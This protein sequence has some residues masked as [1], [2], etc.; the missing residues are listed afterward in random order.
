M[1]SQSEKFRK[2]SACLCLFAMSFSHLTFLYA[3]VMRDVLIQDSFMPAEID[4]VIDLTDIE[5]WLDG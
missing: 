4:E 1:F 2:Y 5:L 3:D